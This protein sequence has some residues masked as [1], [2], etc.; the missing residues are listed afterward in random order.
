MNERAIE[1]LHYFDGQRLH[2]GDLRLEQ[3]YHIRLQRWLSRSLFSAGV[4][5]GFDVY[6]V[7]DGNRVRVTPGLALD[8]QGRAI[9]LVEPVELV[10]RGRY[11]CVRY[12]ERKDGVQGDGCSIKGD[13]GRF[14]ASW[15]GRER[16]LSEPELLW[17]RESPLDETRELVIAVLKLDASGKVEAVESGPRLIASSKPLAQV[18]PLSLEGEKDIDERDPEILIF[19]IRNRRPASVTLYLCAMK[20]STLHY[21]EV[22]QITPR[23]TGSDPDGAFRTE[24]PDSVDPHTHEAGA[25]TADT[26]APLHAHAISSKVFTPNINI[27]GAETGIFV[28]P[29]GETVIGTDWVLVPGPLGFPVPVPIPAG[30]LV[31]PLGAPVSLATVTTNF[32]VGGGGHSHD[33]SGKTS[34]TVADTQRAHKHMV[35]VTIAATGS[36]G[37]TSVRGG[38]QLTF[39]TGLEIIVDG[40]PATDRILAQL[41]ATNSAWSQVTSFD[42]SDGHP[43]RDGTGPIRLDLIDALSFDPDEVRPHTIAFTVRGAGNGGRIQYNL[44]VE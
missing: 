38:S 4:A 30:M 40:L 27:G 6:P 9:I 16:I 13:D 8:D 21:S 10:P 7:A 31:T 2:A 34:D 28:A 3:E 25:L 15:E 17:R 39:F 33:V 24:T 1:R 36:T 44:Y 12:R 37:P 32:S 5:D 20:F 43:L 41:R 11:L 42:G 35:P 26:E 14:E 23:L 29:V 19:H 22:G 18:R